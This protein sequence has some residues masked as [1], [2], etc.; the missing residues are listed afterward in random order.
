[1]MQIE[2]LTGN[3]VNTRDI[4][5][6]KR[7]SS[8]PF[9]RKCQMTFLLHKTLYFKKAKVLLA[10]MVGEIIFYLKINSIEWGWSIGFSFRSIKK[11]KLKPHVFINMVSEKVNKTYPPM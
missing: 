6:R 7:R 5:D 10:K 9:K 4:K 2:K 3:V 11:G 8:N 1:M